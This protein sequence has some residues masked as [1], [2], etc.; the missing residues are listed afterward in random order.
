MAQ[1]ILLLTFA[2]S[3]LGKMGLC[4]WCKCLGKEK[5]LFEKGEEL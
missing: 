2:L 4:G 3:S 1:P 5:K